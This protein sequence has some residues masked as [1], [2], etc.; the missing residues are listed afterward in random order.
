MISVLQILQDNAMFKKN[1]EDSLFN[2][3]SACLFPLGT[4][5]WLQKSLSGHP[6][7]AQHRGQD[8]SFV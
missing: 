2:H 4:S 3:G 7:P 5:S 1:P 8:A 6:D